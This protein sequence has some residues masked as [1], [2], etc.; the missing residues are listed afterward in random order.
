VFGVVVLT[1]DGGSRTFR[2]DVVAV[3]ALCYTVLFVMGLNYVNLAGLR[4]VIDPT[5]A[6]VVAVL[7]WVSSWGR[8][9]ADEPDIC[10]PRRAS[11]RVAMK[12]VC[13]ARAAGFFSGPAEQPTM[14]S[15]R[16]LLLGNDSATLRP[17]WVLPISTFLVTFAGYAA[18]VFAVA[19][20]VVFVPGD[21]ALVGLAVC[22]VVGYLRA[23]L[24]LAWAS[25]YGALLGSKADHAFFGLS[26]RSRIDQLAYFVELDGLVVYAVQ[27]L[28]IGLIGVAV[29]TLAVA[30]KRVL[31]ERAVS[32]GAN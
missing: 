4:S 26:G 29:G 5:L 11:P 15:I 28:V 17:S 21:A 9:T 14:P 16:T 25:A 31:A 2:R 23:G 10:R 1:F 13:S 3:A 24:L 32:K 30:V 19:G 6:V 27:A 22:G 7:V 20:G 18:G 12:V 8:S